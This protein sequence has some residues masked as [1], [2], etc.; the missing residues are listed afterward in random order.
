M[1]N[2]IKSVA[3]LLVFSFVLGSA[4]CAKKELNRLN[5][6]S[7][8]ESY[9]VEKTDEMGTLTSLINRRGGKDGYYAAADKDE[10]EKNSNIFLDRFDTFPDIKTTDFILAAVVEQGSDN[11]PYPSFVCYMTFDSAA[12]ARDAYDTLVDKYGDTEDGKTGT[13][14]GVTYCIVSDE[15][16]AGSNKIGS[17]VYLQ[18][19]TV[20]YLRAQCAA[21]DKYKFADTICGKLGLPSPSKAG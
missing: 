19:N 7:A 6:I 8:V 14:S 9:G 21:K 4:G 13:S 20:I 3:L 12:T 5:F 15:S 16:A 1:K 17:G 11:R 2:T 18:G 10:A